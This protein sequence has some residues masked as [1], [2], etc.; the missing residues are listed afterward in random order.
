GVVAVGDVDAARWRQH[1]RIAAQRVIRERIMPA[2][3]AVIAAEPVA[4]VVAHAA[5]L[6]TSSG[7]VQV[8]GGPLDAK[9]AVSEGNN[10][11]LRAGRGW[12]QRPARDVAAEHAA[13]TVDPAV[14]AVFEAVDASLI[15]AGAEAA[16]EFLD[17]VGFA[18]AV[19]VLGVENVRR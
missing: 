14:E 15:V 9:V 2:E 4:P 19:G 6:R 10:V 7:G 12:L 3:V 11:F 18:V 17:D 13:R 8:A 1:M 5:L 16:V